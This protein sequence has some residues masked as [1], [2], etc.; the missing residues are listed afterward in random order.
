[1]KVQT[2]ADGRKQRKKE[3][4]GDATSSTVSM[5]YIIIRA[6]VDVHEVCGVS[7]CNILGAFISA[8]MDK[9]V[10]IALN[11]RLAELVVK[12]EPQIYRQHVIYEKG[13]SVLYITLKKALYRCLILVLSVYLGLNLY[14]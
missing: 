5:E 4:P 12:I 7:I 3:I 6:T 9:D 8:D 10:K 11:V 2:C 1:M 13:R 14:H